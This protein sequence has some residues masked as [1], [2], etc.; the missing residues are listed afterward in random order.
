MKALIHFMYHGQV[1]VAESQLSNILKAAENLKIKGL[2]EHSVNSDKYPVPSSLKENLQLPKMGQNT[3]DKNFETCSEE[4]F[5]NQPE[6]QNNADLFVEGSKSSCNTKPEVDICENI[7]INESN[8]SVEEQNDQV[9]LTCVVDA[10]SDIMPSKLMEQSMITE[11]VFQEKSFMENQMAS[12]GSEVENEN[13]AYDSIRIN[14][15]KR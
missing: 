3:F 6:F 2:G 13:D 7:K 10:H 14:L 12:S 11:G 5:K 4:S 9:D 1:S 15:R 8:D